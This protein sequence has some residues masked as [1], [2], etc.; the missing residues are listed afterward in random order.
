MTGIALVLSSDAV[1]KKVFRDNVR[2]YDS[3]EVDDFLDIVCRDYASFE[4]FEKEMKKYIVELE[5]NLRKADEKIRH[6]EL[7]NARMSRRLEGIKDND[8]VNS[9]NIDLIQ[10]ISKL[11]KALYALGGDPTR[12]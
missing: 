6:L 4:M 1:L 5:T 7:E 11:E 12:I 8:H 3:D 2:G 9:S 10:R